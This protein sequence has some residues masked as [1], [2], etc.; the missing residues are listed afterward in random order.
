[1][2]SPL[3]SKPLPTPGQSLNRRIRDVLDEGIIVWVLTAF[4]VVYYAGLE[5]LRTIVPQWPHPVVPTFFAVVMVSLAGTKVW[6]GRKELRRLKQGRDG[7]LAVGQFLEQYLGGNGARV[8]HD[9]SAPG[10]NV[11]HVLVHP[12]GIY[13]IETKTLSKPDRGKATLQYDGESVLRNSR[14]LERDPVAQA[15]GSA[16]WLAELIE[17][18]TGKSL[19][20]QPVVLF[21]GWYVERAGTQKGN[22]AW[23][24]NP[25]AFRKW[26]E[27]KKSTLR[28]DM[29]SCASAHLGRYLRALER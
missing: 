20:V 18:Y 23:V 24:L 10:F 28:P 15:R 11:D 3:K 22:E 1:M 16:A 25:K 13:A 19:P 6:R 12:S 7:E 17:E 27:G 21:P 8:F 14:P 2:R 4:F 29:V 5:W 26:V 9:V